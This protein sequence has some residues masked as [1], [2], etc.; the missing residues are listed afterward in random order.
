MVNE[1]QSK[2]EATFRQTERRLQRHLDETEKQL[3]Q[4]RHGGAEGASQALITPEQR[5]VI[6]SL[7]KDIG[8]TRAQ[9][10]AVQLNLN[11][12]I[13]R[14]RAWLQFFN[15]VLVPALLAVAA[16][17][18]AILRSRRRARARA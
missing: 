7:R 15:I 3:Q 18:L 14:L 10:R 12:D 4:L 9:L 8:D 1:M 17:V 6:D 5:G 11:R 2:A 13:S 16:I